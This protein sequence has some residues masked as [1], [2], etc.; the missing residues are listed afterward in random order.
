[1]EKL[2]GVWLRAPNRRSTNTIAS[3]WLR[4]DPPESYYGDRKDEDKNQMAVG[5]TSHHSN[6]SNDSSR[7]QKS[8]E[9]LARH[10][11]MGDMSG[12]SKEKRKNTVADLITA[13]V[14]TYK[15]SLIIV[16]HKRRRIEESHEEGFPTLGSESPHEIQTCESKKLFNLITIINLSEKCYLKASSKISFQNIFDIFYII[17]K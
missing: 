14:G 7:F 8:Y 15:D 16:D 17:S 6:L 9:D 10:K 12:C 3:K 5:F 1:M 4:S 11:S 13:E 2:F